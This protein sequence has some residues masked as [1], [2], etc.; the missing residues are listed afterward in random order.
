MGT[1]V[2]KSKFHL[3]DQ[4]YTHPY[5]F[6]FSQAIYILETLSPN[7]TPLGAGAFT[8]RE[9]VRIHSNIQMSLPPSD[10]L[11]IKDSLPNT[12]ATLVINFLGIAG[13]TGPL[14]NVYSEHINN[15]SLKG[16]H[17][18]EEFLNIFNHRLASIHYRIE[19]K[20]KL[21]LNRQRPHMT[22]AGKVLGVLAGIAPKADL[23]TNKN[24]IS[25]ID[26]ALLRHAGLFWE[27]PVSAVALKS[28]LRDI[29]DLDIDIEQFIGDWYDIEPRSQTRIG[30]D[31]SGKHHLAQ[32]NTLGQSAALG[33]RCWVSNA[34]F[35]IH[36]KLSDLDTYQALL[37]QGELNEMFSKVV[38]HFVGYQACFDFHLIL[39]KPARG[40][41]LMGEKL[42]LGW[43]SWL[44]DHSFKDQAAGGI[45]VEPVR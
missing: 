40:P 8:Q 28:A 45:I 34:K 4:L 21:T 11:T 14:P 17:G 6:E 26:R 27:K 31:T 1:P 23:N 44:L 3:V 22:D 5:E 25:F 16:D 15:R 2:R 18:L 35:R 12:K 20:Y 41:A 7:S 29:F 33:T 19:V 13:Q 9:A 39:Q 38:R 42:A 32:N 10:I 43:T 30:K 37:P 36:I 24:D